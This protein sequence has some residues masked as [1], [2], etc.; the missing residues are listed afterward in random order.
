MHDRDTAVLRSTVGQDRAEVAALAAPEATHMG[1]WAF[2]ADVRVIAPGRQRTEIRAVRG[3][4][5]ARNHHQ[6]RARAAELADR[7]ARR[8][9]HVVDVSI[10]RLW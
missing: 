1:L 9:G 8:L 2:L 6:A 3:I 5:C 4:F 7:Q 10:T